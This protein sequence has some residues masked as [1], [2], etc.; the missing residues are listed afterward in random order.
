M[1]EILA[2]FSKSIFDAFTVFYSLVYS[3]IFN[4]GEGVNK[5]GG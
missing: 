3:E 1:N 2:V 4:K 5:T